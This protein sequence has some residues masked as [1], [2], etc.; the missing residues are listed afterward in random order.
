MSSEKI[1]EDAQREIESKIKMHLLERNMSQTELADLI[2]TSP[3]WVNRAIKGQNTP[4]ANRIRE[5][6]YRVLNI[7]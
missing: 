3:Q 1:L 7:R 6:I 2:G 4:K 5:K